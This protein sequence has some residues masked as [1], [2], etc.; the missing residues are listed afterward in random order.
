MSIRERKAA[1]SSLDK[2]SV[3]FGELRALV[4]KWAGS[5][6]VE[7][8]ERNPRVAEKLKLVE[9]GVRLIQPGLSDGQ[10]T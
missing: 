10:L 9:E 1:A 8:I 2:A 3:M 5:V 7:E 4:R 6:P